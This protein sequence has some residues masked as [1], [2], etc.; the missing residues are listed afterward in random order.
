MQNLFQYHSKRSKNVIQELLNANYE[1]HCKCNKVTG[2]S[3]SYEG[4]GKLFDIMKCAA[5][6]PCFL[7][8]RPITVSAVAQKGTVGRPLLR[9]QRD[10][11]NEEQLMAMNTPFL[12]DACWS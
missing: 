5:N 2:G 7:W 9:P 3:K 6:F 11:K 4:K 1:D 10:I 8:D 12:R